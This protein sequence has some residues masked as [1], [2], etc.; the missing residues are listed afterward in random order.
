MI[1]LPR[2]Q[3]TNPIMVREYGGPY[4]TWYYDTVLDR[5]KCCGQDPD[6][7]TETKTETFIKSA[8]YIFKCDMCGLT[9]KGAIT[10]NGSAANWNTVQLLIN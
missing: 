6:L 10:P 8:V 9:G 7:Y 5:N 3:T 2:K 4:P 1:K